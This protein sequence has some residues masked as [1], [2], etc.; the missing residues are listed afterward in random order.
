[1]CIATNPSVENNHTKSANKEKPVEAPTKGEEK[2]KVWVSPFTPS[3]VDPLALMKENPELTLEEAKKQ[4]NDNFPTKGELKKLIPAH[5][6]EPTVARSMYYVAQDLVQG[7]IVVYA[8]HCVLGVS[9]DP[10]PTGMLAWLGW[11]LAWNVYAIV[12]TFACGGLWV[13]AHECGHGAF[14]K[15]PWVNG[16]VGWILHSFLL[17]PYFSWAFSHAKHHRRTNHLED[18]ETHIPPFA[19]EMG[20]VLTSKGRSTRT[21]PASTEVT[22]RVSSEEVKKTMFQGP[23]PRTF[24]T[25][26]WY[27][28]T[29]LYEFLGDDGFALFGAVYR[30]VAAFHIYLMGV[31]SVGVHGADGKIIPKGTFADH[32]RPTSRL[33][34]EKMYWKVLASDAGILLTLSALAYCSYTFGF[35]A[36][37]FWYVGPYF[38]TN[39]F[40]V[41]TTWM[42]H[43]DPSVPHFDAENW[44]WMKGALSGTIDREMSPLINYVSHNISSTHVVHHLFHQIPHYHA[45]EATKAIRDYLEPKGLYNFSDE[46]LHDEIWKIAKTCH[47]VKSAKEGVQYYQTLANVN[48]P[49]SS[50]GFKKEQ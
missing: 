33:F 28:H 35:R 36:V 10:P 25:H 38:Y 1:M 42:H 47:F 12:M 21:T 18:G 43:T 34:P 4:I 44:T 19:E 6:F 13:L 50:K 29:Q 26:I 15:H 20:L 46:E 11:R 41:A 5:C 23:Q 32:F 17:V 40:L 39:A 48:V 7:A 31:T 8:M 27:G 24:A 2:I 45:V 3:K 9:T 49:D 22:H 16:L 30:L 14:S 37:Y